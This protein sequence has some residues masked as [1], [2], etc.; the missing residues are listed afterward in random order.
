MS[1]HIGDSTNIIQIP[2]LT[3][4]A[5]P[6]GT[7]KT[8]WVIYEGQGLYVQALRFLS[9]LQVFISSPEPKAHR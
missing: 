3:F 5:G 6:G 8:A 9:V 2:T 1:S 4:H 7:A